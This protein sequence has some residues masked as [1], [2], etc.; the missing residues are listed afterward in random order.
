ML[1][2]VKLIFSNIYFFK[3]ENFVNE[4]RESHGVL[5][6][7]GMESSELINYSTEMC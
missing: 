6:F 2:V 5:D 1:F 4:N 7:F 3:E